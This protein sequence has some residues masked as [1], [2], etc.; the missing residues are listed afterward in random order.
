MMIL[1]FRSVFLN[2]DYYRSPEQS[3][4]KIPFKTLKQTFT[5][6][7]LFFV[8]FFPRS[9]KIVRRV[10]KKNPLKNLKIMFKLNP[11][12]KTARRHA[13]LQHDPT[14]SYLCLFFKSRWK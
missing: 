13:I 8:C 1:H 2:P 7:P 3:K 4:K 9:K 5:L 10:L 11:Y 6:K 14:V 12:A